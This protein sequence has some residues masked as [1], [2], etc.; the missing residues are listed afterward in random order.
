MKYLAVAAAL[1]TLSVAHQGQAAERC[2]TA[3][4]HSEVAIQ[5]LEESWS[6]AYWTG[7]TAFLQCLYAPKLLS[8]DSRGKLTSK[9]DDIASSLKN[10]GKQWTSNQHA[11]Q[12]TIKIIG[13]TAVATSFKGDDAHGFRVTDIYE[14]DGK[15]WHAIFSQDTKY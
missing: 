8:A 11:Y 15:Q 14:Y 1:L 12:R 13:N 6:R 9:E 10:R 4:E 3:T 5:Q 2:V 7:D